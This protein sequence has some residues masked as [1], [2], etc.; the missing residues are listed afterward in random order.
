MLKLTEPVID[1]PSLVGKQY[2]WMKDDRNEQELDLRFR[3]E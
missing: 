2:M 3:F 1:E